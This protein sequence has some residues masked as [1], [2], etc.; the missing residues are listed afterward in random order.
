MWFLLL[1]SIEHCLF[2]ANGY[3]NLE[4]DESTECLEKLLGDCVAN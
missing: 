1:H 4:F 2:G 3:T